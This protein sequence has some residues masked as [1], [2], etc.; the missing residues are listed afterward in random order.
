MYLS[1]RDILLMRC[2]VGRRICTVGCMFVECICPVGVDLSRR[3]I[4][5]I[6]WICTV[7][8]MLA[9]STCPVEA[10]C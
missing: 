2:N 6:E 10:S 7:G 5:L 1:R 8:C 9:E 3:S 4:M